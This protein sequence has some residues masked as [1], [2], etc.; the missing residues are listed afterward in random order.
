MQAING[1][2]QL[3]IDTLSVSVSLPI[4]LSFCIA[5]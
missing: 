5:D 3:E 4:D 2:T 1:T